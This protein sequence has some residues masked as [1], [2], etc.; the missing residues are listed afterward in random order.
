MGWMEKY[1]VDVPEG[2]EGGWRVERF[3]V[4][5]GPDLRSFRLALQG[6]PIVPGVYTRLM[7]DGRH[8]PVMSDTPAAVRDMLDAVNRAQG[9]VLV[10][11]LG[12]GVFLKAI[13]LKPWVR[14]V[15]VVEAE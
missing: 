1:R 9:R 11:G 12:L 3:T 13:L 5:S 7:R 8:D 14:Q 4:P 15:D 10:H 2:R 6:R